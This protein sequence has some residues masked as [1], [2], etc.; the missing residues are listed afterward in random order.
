MRISSFIIAFLGTCLVGGPVFSTCI[1]KCRTGVEA[2]FV[3]E[4]T[5]GMPPQIRCSHIP[6]LWGGM[7]WTDMGES[8][9]TGEKEGM[10]RFEIYADISCSEYCWAANGPLHY[11]D[12]TYQHYGAML[13]HGLVEYYRCI[14]SGTA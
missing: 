9:A 12:A 8:L 4:Y 3:M 1:W 14:Q 2:V 5:A 6:F 13:R 11:E 10:V 7:L